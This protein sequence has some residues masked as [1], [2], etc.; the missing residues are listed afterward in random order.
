MLAEAV[1][2]TEDQIA[3]T[4]DQLARQQPD[5]AAHLR[6]MAESARRYA[7]GE[8][9][10]LMRQPGGG[11]AS[12]PDAAASTLTPDHAGGLSIIEERDRIAIQLQDIIVR[13]VFAAGLSLESAAGLATNPEVR[14]RIEAA[15]S[16][17]DQVIREIR[18]AV[19]QDAQHPAIRGLSQDSLDLADQVATTASVRISGQAGSARLLP[20]LRTVLGLIGEHATLVNVDIATSAS[21]CSLTIEAV[22]LTPGE[23]A[24]ERASWLSALRVR[25]VQIGIGVA[26]QPMPGG[27]RFSCQLPVG[28]GRLDVP[29]S[30]L[31]P[32]AA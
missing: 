21:S 11:P 28:L 2:T 8:R 10:R 3:A 27:T 1:A 17:L 20:A 29:G 13:R 25:A 7:A 16:E 12:M 14:G 26:I 6:Y 5:R 24:D 31:S 4:L 9:M 32:L 19:F 18:S 15:V 23:S 30:G 22:P